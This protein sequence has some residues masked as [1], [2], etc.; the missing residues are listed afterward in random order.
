MFTFSFGSAF[1]AAGTGSATYTHAE[2]LAKA[3]ADLIANFTDAANSAKADIAKET[4][5]T[6]TF[7]SYVAHI[8]ASFYTAAVD[9]LVADYTKYV[10]EATNAWM[11][12]NASSNE[13]DPAVITTGIV[14]ETVDDIFVL[15]NAAITGVDAADF[16]AVNASAIKTFVLKGVAANTSLEKYYQ[17]QLWASA[18]DTMKT[19]AKAELAKVDMSLYTEDVISDTDYNALKGTDNVYKVTWKAAA[20]EA[21]DDLTDAINDVAINPTKDTFT[22]TQTAIEGLWPVKANGIVAEETVTDI[23]GDTIVVTYKLA[24]TNIKVAKD[25]S[26]DAA[27]DAAQAAADKAAIQSETAKLLK[28]ALTAYNTEYAAATTDA[29]KKAVADAYADAKDKINAWNTVNTF[30]VDEGN[31]AAQTTITVDTTALTTINADTVLTAAL[32]KVK[33]YETAQDQAAAAKIAVDKDGALKYDAKV[34]DKNLA[35]LKEKVYDGTVITEEATK[36]A[37]LT[38]AKAGAADATPWLKEVALAQAEKALKAD[39]YN[40]DGS[41]KYYD[42]EKAK[43]QANYDK[44]AA[45]INATT[46][47]DQLKVALGTANY[48]VL[49]G[50]QG[51][52]SFGFTN[53]IDNKAAVE[54]SVSSLGNFNSFVTDVNTA[55][56]YLNWGIKAYED[57]YRAAVAENDHADVAKFLAKNGVRTYTELAAKS[58]LAKEYAESLP[59]NGAKK[60]AQAELDAMVKAL[61]NLITFAEKEQV[62][63]AWAFADENGLALPSKLTQAIAL[64]KTAEKKE[65]DKLYNA[66]PTTITVA[67]KDAVKALIAAEDAYEATA[68]YH[69]PDA[70]KNYTAKFEALRAAEKEAVE[71]QIAL[72]PTDTTSKDVETVK[73]AVDAFVAE[74]KDAAYG[75]TGY[76]AVLEDSAA[77]RLAF[78]EAYAVAKQIKAVESLK[79]VARSTPKKGSITV[80]WSVVGEADIDGYQIL[81]SK[82]ANS[83]YKKAFTTTKKSYKNSKGL[84]KGTRYYYKVRAYKVIDGKNVYSDWSNKANRKAK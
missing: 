8:P 72:L 52:Y 74:Y 76:E 15:E 22:A 30:L 33:L 37:I 64:V 69:Y 32:T 60:A 75:K 78:A 13:T 38:D 46:T 12:D 71:K 24:N 18:L 10:N 48:A 17:M 39:L 79:I 53:G 23:N 62:A 59:T 54:T 27:S 4:E 77:D 68:M 80:K 36:T 19:E 67:D 50:G 55:I 73:A 34:I 82:K 65:I 35:D 2:A 14:A 57:G 25:L 49:K 1:G 43:V 6:E 51:T 66:L 29:D 41:D 84:K 63:K 47:E 42:I 56:T 70:H 3:Q 11:V 83:G 31:D 5:Y 9:M 28:A 61:P 40:A 45:K 20:Q 81:K 26:N 44:L 21:I 7:G 58:N 16:P